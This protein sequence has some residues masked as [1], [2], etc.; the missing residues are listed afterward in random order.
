LQVHELYE[1]MSFDNFISSSGGLMGLWAGMS[2][3]TIFQAVSYF[4]TSL[5]NLRPKFTRAH[6]K[7]QNSSLAEM[8]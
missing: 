6:K 5:G 2:F 3:L 7:D 8:M 4:I 1:V